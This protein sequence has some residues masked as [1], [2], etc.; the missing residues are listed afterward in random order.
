MMYEPKTFENRYASILYKYSISI[1]DK[2]FSSNCQRFYNFVMDIFNIIKH[3]KFTDLVH[4][5]VY[6][7]F[8]KSTYNIN[9][10]S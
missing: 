6:V 8:T 4:A 7:K 10:K 3:T 1:L 5:I 2:V 9:L